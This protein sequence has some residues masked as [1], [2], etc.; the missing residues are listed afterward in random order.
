MI[1]PYGCCRQILLDAISI[2]QA[3]TGLDYATF[4]GVE[5][6]ISQGEIVYSR[7]AS[8]WDADSVLSDIRRTILGFSTDAVR[9]P[10]G[11]KIPCGNA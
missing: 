4:G 9:T 1:P 8:E 11:V 10:V 7:R 6:G 3:Q 5:F 2:Q